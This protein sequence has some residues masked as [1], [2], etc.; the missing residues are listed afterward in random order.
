MAVV[1]GPADEVVPEQHGHLE[2]GLLSRHV[3]RHGRPERPSPENHHLRNPPAQPLPIRSCN[4]KEASEASRPTLRVVSRTSL[5]LRRRQERDHRTSFSHAMRTARRR[6]LRALL[7]GAAASPS[8]SSLESSSS[9]GGTALA[10]P[11]KM[12]GGRRTATA[13]RGSW[14]WEW[15]EEGG[16]GGGGGGG[17]WRTERDF[18]GPRFCYL[19]RS[20][21]LQLRFSNFFLLFICF[22]KKAVPFFLT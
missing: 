15:R 19:I 1:D 2:V 9:G 14:S 5:R 17:H 4:R 18:A 8:S 11:V 7:R 22:I 6:S 20:R 10:A 12:G 3:R 16:G 21:L 13:R